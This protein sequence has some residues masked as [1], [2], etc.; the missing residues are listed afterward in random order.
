MWLDDGSLTSVG[1]IGNSIVNRILHWTIGGQPI[2]Q[3]MVRIL[4]L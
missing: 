4:Q 1:I 3:S 2:K